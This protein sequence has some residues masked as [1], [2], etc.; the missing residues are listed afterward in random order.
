MKKLSEIPDYFKQT[1]TSEELDALKLL[2][3]DAN[4][5]TAFYQYETG[6]FDCI[7]FIGPGGKV[8]KFAEVDKYKALLILENK[9]RKE[10]KQFV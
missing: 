4:E 1:F 7:G 8:T 10:L 3:E 9:I 5:L 6:N 2:D